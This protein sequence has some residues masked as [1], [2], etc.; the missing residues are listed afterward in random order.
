MMIQ[1]VSL[2]DGSQTDQLVYLRALRTSKGYRAVASFCSLAMALCWA[3]ATGSSQALSS[4]E[5]LFA[6]IFALWMTPTNTNVQ[7]FPHR[8]PQSQLIRMA[9][10]R[11]S[12]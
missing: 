7:R 8:P 12:T 11:H 9:K 4:A 3:A 10:R 1:A 2:R 5:A 6:A